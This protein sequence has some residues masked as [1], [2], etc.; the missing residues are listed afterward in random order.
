MLNA[1][2]I[3]LCFYLYSVI[4]KQKMETGEILK[5]SALIA[6]KIQNLK[7]LESQMDGFK[8]DS[9]KIETIFL[10]EENVVGFLES[11]EKT[12]E[13]IGVLTEIASAAINKGSKGIVFQINLKGDFEKIFQYLVLLENL[14]HQIVFEGLNM[15][16]EDNLWHSK[17]AIRIISFLPSKNED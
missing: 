8:K 15:Y 10:K 17:I 3:T 16:P 7:L 6:E 12:G 13:D 9:E 5:K 4:Q 2:A 11:L 1:L 14:P